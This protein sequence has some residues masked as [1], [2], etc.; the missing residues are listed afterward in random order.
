MNH[1]IYLVE[2]KQT[3]PISGRLASPIKKFQRNKM[4]YLMVIKSALFFLSL[5]T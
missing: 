3:N 2:I 5:D 1:C 4:M